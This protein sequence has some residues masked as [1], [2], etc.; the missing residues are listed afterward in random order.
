MSNSSWRIFF[1]ISLSTNF[2]CSFMKYYL[3][4]DE[5]QPLSALKVQ[6]V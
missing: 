6:T 5:V 4:D 3:T 2:S 1:R